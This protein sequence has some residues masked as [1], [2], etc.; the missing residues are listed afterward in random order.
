MTNAV[1]KVKPYW[2]IAL[3]SGIAACSSPPDYP[4]EPEIKFLSLSTDTVLQTPPSGESGGTVRVILEFTDGDGDIGYEGVNTDS[5]ILCDPELGCLQ[6]K[7]FNLFVFDHRLPNCLS[8]YQ[9]PYIPQRGSSDAISGTIDLEIFP[10]CCISKDGFPCLSN[11][12]TFDTVYYSIQI[13]DR[14]GHQSNR[15]ELPPIIIECN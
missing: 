7:T 4:I 2:W 14:A 9:V 3:V 1:K 13:K 11:V 6:N 8:P 12:G 15:L 10:V 5:C